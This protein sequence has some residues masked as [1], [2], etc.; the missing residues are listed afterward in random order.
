MVV[1]SWL[2]GLERAG[3]VWYG[4]LDIDFMC[5]ETLQRERLA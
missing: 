2:S 5:L 4:D 3:R 1:E